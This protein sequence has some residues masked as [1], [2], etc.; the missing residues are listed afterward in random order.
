MTYR[1]ND[2]SPPEP[3]F[4]DSY[5]SSALVDTE[6]IDSLTP[7]LKYYTKPISQPFS[8]KM[9]FSTLY[10]EDYATVSFD[11]L[12]KTS[13]SKEEKSFYPIIDHF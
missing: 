1:V 7:L 9:D 3:Y 5:S 6:I 12:L 11:S 8:S 10:L 2:L 13:S 4:H